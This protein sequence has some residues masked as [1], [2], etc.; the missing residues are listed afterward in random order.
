[1]NPTAEK[2]ARKWFILSII[3]RIS[4]KMLLKKTLVEKPRVWSRKTYVCLIHVVS[5]RKY[6]HIWWVPAM[7]ISNAAFLSPP[8]DRGVGVETSIN[9]LCFILNSKF[10]F[11]S[12]Y[13]W[14]TV[15]WTLGEFR[16]L[17]T[18]V[19]VKH[20]QVNKYFNI[21]KHILSFQS[22]TCIPYFFYIFDHSK[23][24]ITLYFFQNNYFLCF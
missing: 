2:N 5:V 8:T 20:V 1:M 13:I 6:A 24:S 14:F 19:N 18:Q 16:D 17:Y 23:Y 7:A 9:I 12:L 4:L 11:G 3:L 10:D 21:Y 15:Q 22:F